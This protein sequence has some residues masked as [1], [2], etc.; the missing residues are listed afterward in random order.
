MFGKIEYISMV[1]ETL[2]GEDL[3]HGVLPVTES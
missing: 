1:Y 3:Q 2:A